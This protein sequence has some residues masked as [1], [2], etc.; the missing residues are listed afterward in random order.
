MMT[1]VNGDDDDMRE[2]AFARN[3]F[4][5][6]LHLKKYVFIWKVGTLF[7]R[8]VA[9]NRSHKVKQES[10]VCFTDTEICIAAEKNGSFLC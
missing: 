9:L 8:C 4:P 2:R 5:F 6:F 7:I 1:V 10:A 3:R